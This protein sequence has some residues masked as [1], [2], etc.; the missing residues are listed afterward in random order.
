MIA[1]Q[2]K[3]K[4]KKIQGNVSEDI[5]IR[6]HRSISWLNCA[7]QSK[8]NGDIQFIS[9]WIS[10][11]AC[12]AINVSK[13]ELL[14]EKENFRE[15]IQKLVNYD[16]E[17]RFY[18]LL[19]NKFSGTIRVLIENKYV[20][21]PFWDYQR[22]ESI[23]WKLLHEKSIAD[24]LKYLSNQKVTNLL[25]QVLDRLYTLR[26]QLIHGG[27]TYKSKVNREQVKQ[28]CNMLQLLIPI[29]ID[30]LMENAQEDWGEIYYPVI[31]E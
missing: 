14:S 16:V 30:I 15:F 28:G 4:L 5:A 23:N 29:I 21:K 13:E 7:E 1:S 31:N 9:L 19:W 18:Q 24:S 2:L 27:A 17:K 3:L 11:N 25:E 20:F 8:G 22:G 12:Y 10:F 6:L 26:N